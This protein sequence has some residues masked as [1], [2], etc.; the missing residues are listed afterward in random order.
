MVLS[1][2]ANAIPNPFG[3]FSPFPN[4]IMIPFMQAQS[5]ALAYGFGLDYE[6]GKRTIKAMSNEQFNSLTANDVSNLIK[7]HN[8]VVLQQLRDE[9]PNFTAFQS[10]IIDKQVEIEVAKAN[11]T[12]SAMAE[13]VTALLSGGHQATSDAI[14]NYVTNAEDKNIAL[15]TLSLISPIFALMG[16]AN[17]EGGGTTE[18]PNVQNYHIRGTTYLRQSTSSTQND[19]L[20][21]YP[22]GWNE[23]Q[24]DVEYNPD[25]SKKAEL[26]QQLSDKMITLGDKY[27]GLFFNQS[28][29]WF[30]GYF[31]GINTGNLTEKLTDARDFVI[32]LM[33]WNV[34][35]Y[36]HP[37][38]QQ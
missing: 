24:F 2:L 12:P 21:V 29:D 6:F 32:A 27:N 28:V 31:V 17:A 10:E 9:L 38:G 36:G 14:D 7:N 3:G 30:N 16:L 5:S 18:P 35:E 37:D 13:I 8:D 19:T 23:G 4:S 25:L 33:K 26:Q 15:Q 22:L 11:R 34:L 20:V 1:S